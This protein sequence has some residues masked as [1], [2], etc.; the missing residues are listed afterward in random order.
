MKYSFCPFGLVFTFGSSS[1]IALPALNH[2]T[3]GG[4][5]KFQNKLWKICFDDEKETFS[6][7][8]KNWDK[9]KSCSNMN[10]PKTLSR[11]KILVG[12]I[13][14]SDFLCILSYEISLLIVQKYFRRGNSIFAFPPTNILGK[15]TPTH[16]S[17]SR[18]EQCDS[19]ACFFSYFRRNSVLFN[20]WRGW[21]NF[22]KYAEI[23]KFSYSWQW[24]V[25]PVLVCQHD[26]RLRKC[27]DLHPHPINHL[28]RS[29][30]Q[31]LQEE[32][33]LIMSVSKLVMMKSTQHDKKRQY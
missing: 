18:T 17:L 5:W 11:Q 31:N 2:F 19:F 14:C 12:P 8:N 15:G 6:S 27:S 9:K 10:F 22:Y 30:F 21:N 29:F 1:P 26:S 13:D 16:L 4:G 24:R 23:R 20:S 7:Q 3:V 32:L 25:H 28:Y 33:W